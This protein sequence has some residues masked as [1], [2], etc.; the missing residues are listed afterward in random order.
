MVIAIIFFFLSVIYLYY[1]F[2]QIAHLPLSYQ[3]V[4]SKYNKY[5]WSIKMFISKLFYIL[6]RTLPHISILIIN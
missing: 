4:S 1:C 3:T 2:V 5:L 6:S